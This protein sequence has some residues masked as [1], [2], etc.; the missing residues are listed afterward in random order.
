M[1][2]GL[3]HLYWGEG[4]G[5]TTA[6][7]GL[8]VRALGRGRSVCFVQFLKDGSSGEVA[9][10]RRLGATVYHGAPGMKFV[11]EMQEAE[12]RRTR[13]EQT[14]MLQTALAGGADLLVL[15]E[16]CAACVLNMVDT[17]L[18]RTAVL[19]KPAAQELVL[20]GR[21]PA[22]WMQTAA[23]YATEMRCHR[24]PY[25]NGVSARLGVEF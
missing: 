11:F 2:N 7:V 10:L 9:M 20:T 18:L 13:A 17:A 6:A 19:Q 21:D 24:H 25:E 8:A 4:K 14:K 22:G 3:V 15:D 5:K 16:A 1:Q 12:K 23:D